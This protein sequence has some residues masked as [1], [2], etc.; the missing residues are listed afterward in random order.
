MEKDNQFILLCEEKVNEGREGR[1]TCMCASVCMCVKEAGV[2]EEGRDRSEVIPC[3]SEMLNHLAVEA[4][5]SDSE[6]FPVSA[7]L[8]CL[9]RKVNTHTTLLI[10]FVPPWCILCR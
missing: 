6:N 8:Y 9:Y 7:Q 3:H 5:H 10:P 4:W 2:E 1:E